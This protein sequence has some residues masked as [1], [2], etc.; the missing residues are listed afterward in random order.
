M[1]TPGFWN[2][3]TL[4]SVSAALFCKVYHSSVVC[5]VIG[6]VTWPIK[7][8]S[9]IRDRLVVAGLGSDLH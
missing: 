1:H 4:I 9:T 7:T 2:K 3:C 8:P 6:T 5:G